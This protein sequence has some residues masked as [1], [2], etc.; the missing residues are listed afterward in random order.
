[1][2]YVQGRCHV[3]TEAVETFLYETV[4]RNC[5]DMEK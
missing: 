1:V 5:S 4:I 2:L 3:G